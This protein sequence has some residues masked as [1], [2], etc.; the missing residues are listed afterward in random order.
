MFYRVLATKVSCWLIWARTG[1]IFF[2]WCIQ[3][4][5]KEKPCFQS[6]CFLKASP[7]LEVENILIW[8]RRKLS[9]RSNNFLKVMH[10]LAV[11]QKKPMSGSWTSSWNSSSRRSR[12]NY[13][14][15]SALKSPNLKQTKLNNTHKTQ[16]EA[17]E[18]NLVIS[19]FFE[20]IYC[21][22]SI[23]GKCVFE[24]CYKLTKLYA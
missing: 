2:N 21:N 11:L 17:F 20:S 23:G 13:K 6:F 16:L 10:S 19:V 4:E 8:P 22:Q 9:L 24:V 18:R 14:L 12:W 1:V 3:G 5:K 15:R 7:P